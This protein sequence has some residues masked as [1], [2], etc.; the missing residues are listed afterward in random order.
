MVDASQTRPRRSSLVAT[1]TPA[2]ISRIT[3]TRMVS[4]TPKRAAC[5]QNGNPIRYIII[6]PAKLQVF[7]RI[8]DYS[9]K[10]TT[11]PTHDLHML[12]LHQAMVFCRQRDVTQHEGSFRALI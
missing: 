3:F 4:G 10:S 12:N 8:C 11:R 2:S 7:S 9:Y 1:N 6:S 5:F